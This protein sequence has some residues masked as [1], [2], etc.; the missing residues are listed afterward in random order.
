M[1][2]QLLELAPSGHVSE[3]LASMVQNGSICWLLRNAYR[4]VWWRH[5]AHASMDL[6]P[7]RHRDGIVF[8][9]LLN[10]YTVL[11]DLHLLS[12]LKLARLLHEL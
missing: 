10:S 9:V 11:A 3:L 4:N 12:I 7:R 6:L 1:V 2:L 8:R 5:W